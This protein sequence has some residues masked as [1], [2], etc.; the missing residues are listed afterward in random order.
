M[1]IH[2]DERN[3]RSQSVTS[4]GA[5]DMTKAKAIRVLVAG[6]NRVCKS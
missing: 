5:L 1:M 4:G 2:R 3:S 6:L